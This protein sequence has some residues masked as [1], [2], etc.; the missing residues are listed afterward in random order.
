M[1]DDKVYPRIVGARACHFRHGL[2]QRGWE[3]R[4]SAVYLSR[5]THKLFSVVRNILPA[6]Y[7]GKVDGVDGRR[8]LAENSFKTAHFLTGQTGH[9]SAG[10]APC[11]CQASRGAEYR[12]KRRV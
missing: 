12:S 1:P 9:Y 3:G 7:R 2:G 6:L 4:G 10:E 5:S 11:V 8:F